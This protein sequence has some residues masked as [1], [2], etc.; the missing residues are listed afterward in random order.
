MDAKMLNSGTNSNR[1][2][3]SIKTN[4]NLTVSIKDASERTQTSSEMELTPL[5]NH[6]EQTSPFNEE[7]SISAATQA[8]A[9]HGQQQVSS[10]FINEDVEREDR[11]DEGNDDNSDNVGIDESAILMEERLVR[12]VFLFF[13]LR[14]TV[15]H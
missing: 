3:P 15:N 2:A 8:I 4:L 11:R 6:P 13:S 7:A 10:C 14:I 12:V 1:T 5:I 9:F